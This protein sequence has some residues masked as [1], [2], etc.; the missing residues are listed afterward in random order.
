MQCEIIRHITAPPYAAASSSAVQGSPTGDLK[1]YHVFRIRSATVRC[2]PGNTLQLWSPNWAIRHVVAAYPTQPTCYPGQSEW[3]CVCVRMTEADDIC[4]WDLS[5]KSVLGDLWRKPHPRY[6]Q[7]GGVERK[8]RK[9]VGQTYRYTFT[10]MVPTDSR[11][12]RE[13]GNP[14]QKTHTCRGGGGSKLYIFQAPY[15]AARLREKRQLR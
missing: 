9:L 6:L 12:H 15:A 3:V 10:H 2:P 5:D 14:I 8:K 11:G 13:W 4:S 7:R 1:C